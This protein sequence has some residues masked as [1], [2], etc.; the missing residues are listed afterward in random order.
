VDRLVA[1][2]V[3][4]AGCSADF[5]ALAR[6]ASINSDAGC[7]P[8]A[9]LLVSFTPSSGIGGSDQG[10][11]ALGA[12]DS[13]TVLVDPNAKLTLGFIS[14]GGVV[15]QTGNDL[16]VHGTGAAGLKVAAYVSADGVSFQYSGEI[17]D[18]QMHVD[19]AVASASVV[20]YL[21]LIGLSG[22]LTVDAVESVQTVCNTLL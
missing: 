10:L 4:L 20:V 18:T 19:V 2:L 13:Q 3:L 7:T 1:A 14:L 11:E 17:N 12:P 8:F 21:R 15:D 22:V 6:D 9:D 5:P 16:L